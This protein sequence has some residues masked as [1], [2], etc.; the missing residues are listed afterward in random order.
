MAISRTAALIL[1]CAI[2]SSMGAAEQADVAFRPS[3]SVDATVAH[4][5][6]LANATADLDATERHHLGPLSSREFQTLVEETA[7]GPLRVGLTRN[8]TQ[9]VEL[10]SIQPLTLASARR[11]IGGGLLRRE[12]DG[13]LTWTLA[14]TSTAAHALRLHF[15]RFLLPEGAKAYVYSDEG[16]VHGPYTN[17]FVRSI[18]PDGRDFWTNTV[19]ASTI[20]LEVQFAGAISPV[21]LSIDAAAHLEFPPADPGAELLADAE[22]TEC[23]VDVAC[24]QD[25]ATLIESLSSAAARLTYARGGSFYF[26]TGSLVNVSKTPEFEPYMLTANHCFNSQASASSL[27]ALWNYRAAACGA[28]PPSPS[29][30]PRNLGA[31]LLATAAASDFTFI[32]LLQSPPGPR[33]FLGWNANASAVTEGATF[34]RVS[35][36]QGGAQ[37]FSRSA[38]TASPSAGTCSGLPTTSFLYSRGTYGGT[39]GGSSGGPM[40]NGTSQIL[41]QLFGKCGTDTSNPCNYNT[42]STV[43]G[44][45]FATYPSVAQWLN[46]EGSGSQPCVASTTT[47]C[48]QSNRFKVTLAARDPR[49]GKTDSGYVMSSTN[50]FGYY[51]FPVLAGNQTDPQIFIKVLDGRPINNKW[52]VFYASLTDVE[53]TLTVT[54]TTNGASKQYFQAPYTQRSANDTNAFN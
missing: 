1:A 3:T 14:V 19:Y 35:H 45:F 41:G 39:T 48:V 28:A 31:T 6:D 10:A 37:R 33:S 16:E 50:F 21:D 13:S 46:P 27:E 7:G 20:Y 53:F 22:A 11:S 49:T 8:L 12:A 36:P 44:A 4:V 51:A 2:S 32:E 52:W 47:L 40:T 54:D 24:A 9:P 29:T 5:R 34:Y 18:V 26:C 15:D 43:D 42:Q 17:A 25:N 38:Y 30:L 23:F